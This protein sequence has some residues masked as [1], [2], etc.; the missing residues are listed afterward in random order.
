MKQFTQKSIK[1]HICLYLSRQQK[2]V[3]HEINGLAPVEPAGITLSAG[4][5]FTFVQNFS[6]FSTNLYFSPVPPLF[7]FFSPRLLWKSI[8]YLY[9]YGVWSG[10]VWSGGTIGRE[11]ERRK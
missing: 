2:V 1:A 11:E 9:Y 6:P 5:M 3:S 10:V 7:L 8:R 4:I